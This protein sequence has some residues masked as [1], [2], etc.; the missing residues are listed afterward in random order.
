MDVS[1][2]SCSIVTVVTDDLVTIRVHGEVDLAT[3]PSLDAAFAGVDGARVAVDLSEMT[4]C[5]AAGLRVLE[6]AHV[7]LGPRLQVTGAQS[8]VRRLARLLDLPW[9][10]DPQS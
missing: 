2:G 6:L 1:T 9:I 7:R 4:F 3:A 5:D 8:L 10:V